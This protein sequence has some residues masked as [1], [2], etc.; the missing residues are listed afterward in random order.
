MI[1]IRGKAINNISIT[2][3]NSSFSMERFSSDFILPVIDFDPYE[4]Y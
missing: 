1:L 4:S 2:N 3:I